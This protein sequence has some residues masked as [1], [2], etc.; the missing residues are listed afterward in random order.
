MASGR[1]SHR[2]LSAVAAQPYA[3]R[4][5]DRARLLEAIG[6]N[7]LTEELAGL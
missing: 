1:A 4:T 7:D 5:P 2:R 6:L 3:A